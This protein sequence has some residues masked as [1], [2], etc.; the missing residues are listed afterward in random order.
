MDLREKALEEFKG[1][2][3]TLRVHKA[4]GGP[5]RGTI[6][7][8][9]VI[10]ER[11][12]TEY[13][14]DLQAHRAPGGSQLKGAGGQA[15]KKILAR[16]GEMRP[17]TAEGGRTNRG[18]PGDILSLLETLASLN[19][20]TIEESERNTILNELQR[21]L[22]ERVIDYHSRQRIKLTF[23]PTKTTWQT[24][25]SLLTAAHETGKEGPVAQHLVGAKLELRFPDLAI[26][27]ESYSTADR[28]LGRPGDFMIGDTAFHVTVSPMPQLFDKCVENIKEGY[29][30][31]LLVPDRTLSGARQNAELMLPGKIVVESIE[32][33]VATNI[34]ELSLFSKN[35]VVRGMRRLLET[36]NRRVS[37]C[38]M[39]K[40]ML[41]EIPR[42]I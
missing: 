12:K 14:L 32:S 35:K 7:A 36:Y 22:V 17:F 3:S 26:G 30:A 27:N 42:N 21:F 13:N 24:I 28:Q 34:E 25:Q 19:L 2:F 11:L 38:E 33:F 8:G 16:F 41:I 18:G 1:W 4:S 40:S 39:D 31:F 20:D 29:R 5:A 10:L 15:E 6:S 23:D 9:L 37:E